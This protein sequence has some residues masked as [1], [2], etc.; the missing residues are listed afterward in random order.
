[1]FGFYRT[2]CFVAYVF[3]KIGE[4]FAPTHFHSKR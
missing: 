1:M 4:L 2:K 3:L